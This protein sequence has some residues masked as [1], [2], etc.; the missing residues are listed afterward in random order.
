MDAW[1]RNIKVE[2]TSSKLKK[3]FSFGQEFLEG[4]MD[5]NLDITV[6]KYMSSLKDQAIVE[7]SNLTQSEIVQIIMGEFF[8]I[9]IYCGYKTSGLNKIFSGG[10]FYISNRL[11]ADRTNTT[12]II[13]TSNL[14]AKY[15]Q[16]RLNLTL[17]SGINLYSAVNFILRRAGAPNS[18]VSTQLKKKFLDEVTT[19]NQTAT[20]WLDTL[21]SNNTNLIQNSDSIF[22]STFSIFDAAKSNNRVIK[23]TPENILL[24][25]GYPRMTQGG[26]LQLTLLPSF[27]FMCGDVINIDNSIIDISV[28]SRDEVLQNYG[29]YLSQ[30]GN[31]MIY[32]M[33]YHICNRSSDYTLMLKCK[34]RDRIAAYIGE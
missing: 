5:L 34:N 31:Y 13:C 12:I 26:N 2:L 20:S 33:Q 7:I 3:S 32:E 24:T 1:V 23:L 30:T 29:A 14:V 8:N 16:S 6:N 28:S 27:S 10:V 21:C 19:V 15:G 18:N 4:R 11:N 22:D 9:D 17:N 25:G